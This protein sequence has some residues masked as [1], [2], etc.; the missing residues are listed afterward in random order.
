[1]DWFRESGGRKV[2]ETVFTVFES[3]L[4]VVNKD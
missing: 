1:M 2:G 4:N 3:V